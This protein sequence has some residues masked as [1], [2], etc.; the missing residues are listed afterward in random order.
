MPMVSSA[1]EEGRFFATPEAWRRWLEKNHAKHDELWVGFHKRGTGKKSITWPEAVDEALCYGWIDG[2]RKSIDAEAYRIRFT[3][4]KATST[5][6]S[7]NVR[8]IAELEK[9][10]KMTDAGR[11]AFAK[12]REAKTGI[13]GHERT[14]AAE[15]E[16]GWQAR[17]EK[18]KKAWTY[19]QGE[20]PWYRR[21]A[22]HWVMS[23]KKEETRLRRFEQ[24]L[25][26]SSK[27]QRI[28]PIRQGKPG[29]T[30]ERA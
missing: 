20:A 27:Q 24:L 9:L 3:P 6:S 21:I 10:G 17:L 4:R 18:D 1:V 16:P 8:R 23:A 29:G 11:A 14:K 2:L 12:R 28:G 13:Y 7:V 19:F 26:D 30:S 5:W 25:A 15:L 22:Y